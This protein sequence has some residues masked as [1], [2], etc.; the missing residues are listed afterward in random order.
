MFRIDL[1]HI[2]DKTSFPSFSEE[3]TTLAEVVVAAAAHLALETTG[4]VAPPGA[5][6]DIPWSI[7]AL[8]KFGGSELGFGSDIELIFVYDGALNNGVDNRLH[9]YFES[10]V[11]AFEASIHARQNGVFEIDLRL[12]PH[13][14]A[15]A[16]AVPLDAFRSY[17]SPNGDAQP[18]ERLALVKLRPVAGD[19]IL[20]ATLL[21]IRD[22]W[23]YSS[24]PVDLDDMRGLRQRQADELVPPGEV[25]AKYSPGGLGDVEYYVQSQQIRWG[26]RNP[27]VRATNTLDAIAGLAAE[28]AL[29]AA[30]AEGLIACY[31]FLRQ[32][33][34]ALRVVRGN[35][36]DLN[37]PAI[38]SNEFNYLAQRLQ[39]SS[40]D[41]L[42]AAIA[43]RMSQSASVW[44]W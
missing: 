27:R 40:A 31:S 4:D 39:L 16:L 28:G 33:I 18:F 21:A 11:R 26:R 5:L 42:E 15:G 14:S 41:A 23:V 17:Y 25:N 9:G 38:G 37:I 22:A 20:G 36:K 35:A 19:P 44:D 29:D 3:L 32:L 7:A 6:A 30:R 1:R 13:G 24:L 2:T 43:A 34:D 10:F 8:G 12:R